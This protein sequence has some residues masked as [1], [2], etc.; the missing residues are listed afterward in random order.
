[1]TKTEFVHIYLAPIVRVLNERILAV[2]YGTV[3]EQ[4]YVYCLYRG[5]YKKINVTGDS[6]ASLAED[7]IRRVV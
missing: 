5:G 4:E 6:F 3:G 1:M 7:V 2:T